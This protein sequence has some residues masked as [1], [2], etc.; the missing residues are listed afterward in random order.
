MGVI[1]KG[2]HLI[3]TRR[4]KYCVVCGKPL[5]VRQRSYCSEDCS[6]YAHKLQKRNDVA[7]A[8]KLGM[9]YK[10]YVRTDYDRTD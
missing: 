3:L 7:S 6:A 1:E 10:A 9:T 2:G 4:Q 8:H 5:T